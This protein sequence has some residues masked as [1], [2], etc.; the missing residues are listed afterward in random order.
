MRFIRTSELPLDAVVSEVAAC[1]RGGGTVIFP[2]ETVYGIGCAPEDA[3][4]IDRI[5]HVKG[6]SGHKPLA[7]H[8]ADA[9]QAS[10]YV[11][12]MTPC[13][14]LVA[15]RFWPGP[16]AIIVRRAAQR[17]T[18]TPA[19]GPM[20]ANGTRNDTIIIVTCLGVP[21]RRNEMKL[22]AA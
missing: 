9:A 22:D 15:Q 10:P 14:R 20:A 16:V 2:T 13:A 4:A 17:S 5:F 19:I 12:V 3:D 11:E 6:R 8:I 1:V 18:N 7:L 21:C